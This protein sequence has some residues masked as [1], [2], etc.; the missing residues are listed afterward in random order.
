MV[1]GTWTQQVANFCQL[2]MLIFVKRQKKERKQNK[3]DFFRKCQSQ[4]M[5][6]I[7]RQEYELVQS[8]GLGETQ[9]VKCNVNAMKVEI[10]I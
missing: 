5:I 1:T 10:M 4:I 6:A 2:K 3:T 9:L 8:W 7:A